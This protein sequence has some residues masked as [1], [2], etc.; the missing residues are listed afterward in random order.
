MRAG[1]YERKINYT[2]PKNHESVLISCG[3]M[4]I[5][6]KPWN[7]TQILRTLQ[8]KSSALIHFMPLYHFNTHQKLLKKLEQVSTYLLEV[9]SWKFILL[10]SCV[11]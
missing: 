8:F 6:L 11:E 9:P 2:W 5:P 7:M 1:Y 10:R 4:E 3:T